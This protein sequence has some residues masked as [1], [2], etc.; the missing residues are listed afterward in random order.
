MAAVAAR[1]DQGQGVLATSDAVK[2]LVTSSSLAL[3]PGDLLPRTHA[4]VQVLKD[5]EQ[6]ELSGCKVLELS[7]EREE[8]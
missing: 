2:G 4:V 1:Q 5:R 7:R 6:A 8:K 3:D